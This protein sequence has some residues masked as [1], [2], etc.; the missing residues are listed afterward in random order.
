[1]TNLREKRTKIVPEMEG[2][3][4]RWYARLRGTPSQMATYRRDAAELTAGLP[5]GAAVL[6]VAPG[7]GYLAV[8]I[9]RLGRFRVTGLDVSRTFVQIAGEYARREG[10]AVEFR[11]GDVAAMPFEPA[12]FDLIVCQ[13]AFKNFTR[14]DDAL[15]EMHRVL[16]PGGRAVIQDLSREA[17]GAD[18]R[19]E[20]EGMHL[21][22]L[23]AIASRLALTMLRR[24]AY[25]RARFERLVARGP[26]RTGDI[27]IDGVSL[28]AR[29]TK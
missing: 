1:M 24:R 10:V 21:G 11:H 2:A 6:E 19:R 4:A 16:R 18:I 15:A 27:S 14:P 29:L 23:N 8:E 7:P 12:S 28:D 26:F 5:E 3:Q 9:A 13:A 17:T 25:T 22:R 20:I